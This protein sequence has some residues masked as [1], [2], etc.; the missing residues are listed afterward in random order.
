MF[1]KSKIVI[2]KADSIEDM[3]GI[4]YYI[5]KSPETSSFIGDIPCESDFV[6]YFL[7]NQHNILYKVL[8]KG[9]YVG[10][11]YIEYDTYTTGKCHWGLAE[12][13]PYFFNIVKSVFDY[14]KEN[15]T[16]ITFISPIHNKNTV[17]KKIAKRVGYKKILDLPKYY[18]IDDYELWCYQ[19]LTKL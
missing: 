17:A 19:D 18:G 8:S 7:Y 13:T 12:Y 15:T 3:R 2:I 10:Y 14:I 11:G 4:Y 9:K 5:K 6:D 1:D 16:L